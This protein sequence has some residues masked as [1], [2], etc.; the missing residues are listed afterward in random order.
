MDK[1][2]K[3][4]TFCG[5]EQPSVSRIPEIPLVNYSKGGSDF[6][7]Y[8]YSSMGR[9]IVSLKH[10]STAA[11]SPFPESKRFQVKSEKHY[12]KYIGQYSS[13]RVQKLSHKP[14]ASSTP[15]GTSTRDSALKLYTVYTDKK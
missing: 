2:N 10:M 1:V 13:M 15:F 8:N 6:R 5:K 7:V 12:P 9:Q 4:Q 11:T 3:T 14:S